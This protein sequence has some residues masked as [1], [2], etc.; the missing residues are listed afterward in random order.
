MTKYLLLIIC[1]AFFWGCKKPYEPPEIKAQNNFLVVDGVINGGTNGVTTIRLSRTRSLTDTVVFIPEN[2]A[3]IAIESN[4]G[5]RY[6]LQQTGEG[7]YQTAALNLPAAAKY[8][9]N[10]R[11]SNGSQYV[12]DFVDILQ[13]PAIDSVN[14]KQE[15]DVQL[16]VNTHDP[17]NKTRYYRWD[18][19]ETWEYHASIETILEFKNG[20][21]QFRDT[22]NYIDKCWKNALSSSILVHSTIKLSQDQVDQFAIATIPRNDEK[23]SFKY[24]VLVKQYALTPKAYEY[25]NTL[26]KNSEE[27]GSLF[28]AQPAQIFGNV[29]NAADKAEKVIGYITA[30]TIS[31]KRIFIRES[32]LQK[33]VQVPDCGELIVGDP[34]DAPKILIDKPG[35]APAYNVTGGGLVL[36]KVGC[37]D[38]RLKGGITTKPPFWQ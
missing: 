17:Q 3:Q 27:L 12:S 30:S 9:L 7:D 22:S 13:T 24:S 32:E 10:I 16:Y 23:V 19:V 2:G 11:T 6:N 1:V 29:H 35:L 31:E 36:A 4:S 20:K 14:W 15:T 25:W 21:V 33:E 8:R 34:A 18:F 28:D 37:V 38:C 26:K 5:S